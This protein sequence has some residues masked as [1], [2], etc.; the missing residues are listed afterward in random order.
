VRKEIER[1]LERLDLASSHELLLALRRAKIRP[2]LNLILPLKNIR[3]LD[4]LS[5]RAGWKYGL[6]EAVN[7]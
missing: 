1:S 7:A 3:V 4:S 5:R 6:I 2:P